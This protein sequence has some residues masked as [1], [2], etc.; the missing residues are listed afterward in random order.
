MGGVFLIHPERKSIGRRS[1]LLPAHRLR[2]IVQIAF[3]ALVAFMS[4]AKFLLEQGVALPF[5]SEVSLHTVCPFGGVV[6]I[7]QLI[8]DGTFVQKIHE[9]ALVLMALVFVLAILFG[10]VFC[11]WFCPFGSFQ[12]WLGKLGRK[13]FG[14]RFNHLVPPKIDRVLRYLRYG[15]LGM[16]VYMTAKTGLLVFQNVDPYYALFNFYS[17]EVAISALIA[18]FVVV[19]LSLVVER[20]FCKYAC[21]YGALLGLTNLFRVFGIRRRP[22]SCIGC[23]ACDRA[24]PMNIPVSE[25]GTVRNPQCISCMK[26]TS[27]SACPVPGTVTLASKEEK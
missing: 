15:V 23:K 19:I 10:P 20:P 9:S 1:P 27:E 26:C 22:S 21:P 7:Y 4:V 8:A 5:V 12:E 6:S 16:V 18:L 14:K 25:S 2:T 17:G 11:G 3:F 24:C 13:V